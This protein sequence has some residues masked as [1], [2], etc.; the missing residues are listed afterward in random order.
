M[1]LLKEICGFL[2]LAAIIVAIGQFLPVLNVLFD[3]YIAG[4]ILAAIIILA[5]RM[6]Y[7]SRMAMVS[8][9]PPDI[10]EQKVK[11][12][13]GWWEETTEATYSPSRALDQRN[14][15]KIKSIF[16]RD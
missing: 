14:M 1:R 15:T 6:L 13:H 2:L 3:D 4:F 11:E 9:F 5:T 16:D 8:K 10:C 7:K 12:S